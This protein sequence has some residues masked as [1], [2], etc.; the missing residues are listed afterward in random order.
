MR[1]VEEGTEQAGV[2]VLQ[3]RSALG[4]VAACPCPTSPKTPP[5]TQPTRLGWV[6]L[7]HDVH[8]AAQV[9]AVPRVNRLVPPRQHLRSAR[10]MDSTHQRALGRPKPRPATRPIPTGQGQA[11]EGRGNA[12]RR[13]AEEERQPA[14]AAQP[15][16]S[17]PAA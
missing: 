2:A 17:S 4:G 5:P 16:A 13:Q 7:Q 6:A 3:G 12:G 10:S 8:Q 15:P 9:Q 11:Q 14:Q 1:E